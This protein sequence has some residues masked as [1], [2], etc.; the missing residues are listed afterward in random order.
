MRAIS[1]R[2]SGVSFFAPASPPRRPPATPLRAVGSSSTSPVAILITWTALEGGALKLHD[3]D[4]RVLE[5]I[6]GA[7]GTMAFAD[8]LDHFQVTGEDAAAYYASVRRLR[9]DDP[10]GSLICCEP[11][12]PR[13]TD[14][15]KHETRVSITEHGKMECRSLPDCADVG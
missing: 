14:I 13:P 1:L 15:R 12:L 3:I 6:Y 4:K 10:C 2:C 9:D 11:A 8:I 5:A 7:G